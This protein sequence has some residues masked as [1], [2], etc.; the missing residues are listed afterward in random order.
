[1]SCFLLIKLK[2]CSGSPTI[3]L[4]PIA[5]LIT[6]RETALALLQLHTF[7]KISE[8]QNRAVILAAK[9]IL[10]KFR[11]VKALYI[12]DAHNKKVLLGIYCFDGLRWIN[13]ETEIFNFLSE[14]YK[15][16]ELD[17][18]GVNYSKL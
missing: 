11:H 18:A 8:K 15:R 4:L 17:L 2:I 13:C 10:E 12:W 5:P 3:I 16:A 7:N 14:L 1:M 6:S 9:A